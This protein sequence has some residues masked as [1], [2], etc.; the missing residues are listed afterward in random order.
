M[1]VEANERANE[2]AKKAAETR[3][4]QRCPER[5]TSLAHIGRTVTE[6]K[7]K[8]AEHWFSNRYKSRYHIQRA[9]YNPALE[10]QR[11]DETVMQR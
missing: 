2:A 4:I 5:F 9:K 3:G 11:S 6:R 1:G 7:W 10:T 8:E